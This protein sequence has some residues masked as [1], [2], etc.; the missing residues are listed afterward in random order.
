MTTK[1]DNVLPFLEDTGGRGS[2]TNDNIER[3][4]VN[5]ITLEGLKGF[6]RAPSRLC[7]C[8]KRRRIPARQ[9]LQSG[10]S[11]AFVR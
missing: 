2:S 6:C 5:P 4:N 11:E 9:P 8:P 10:Y 1:A 3:G 7:S